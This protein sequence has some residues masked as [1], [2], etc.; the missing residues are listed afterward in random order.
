MFLTPN[1]TL[2]DATHEWRPTFHRS[3]T[4]NRDLPSITSSPTTDR[5]AQDANTSQKAI[6]MS[7]PLIAAGYIHCPQCSDANY[8]T[9]ATRITPTTILATYPNHCGHIT[10]QA[11]LID[12]TRPA[13]QARC[14]ATTRAP[15]TNAAPNP[16]PT[17]TSAAPTPTSHAAKRHDTRSDATR[18]THPVGQPLHKPLHQVEP[19]THFNHPNRQNG[20]GKDTMT[21]HHQHKPE[22]APPQHVATLPDAT[23]EYVRTGHWPVG[24]DVLQSIPNATW[25]RSPVEARLWLWQRS[26]GAADVLWTFDGMTSEAGPEWHFHRGHRSPV[27]YPMALLS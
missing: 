3:P 6:S 10:P 12:T 23:R 7:D 26:G 16:S 4:H 19:S 18:Q 21:T 11:W 17:P 14:R 25:T 1:P 22:T 13:Y 8:P 2:S 5:D 20:H 24:S 9:E 27:G 15:D